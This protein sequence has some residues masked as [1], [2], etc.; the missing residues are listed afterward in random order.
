MK[1]I[2]YIAIFCLVGLWC[3]GT[4]VAENDPVQKSIQVRFSS[5]DKGEAL[6]NEI[7]DF[8]KHISP[9]LGRLGCNGRACHGSFQGQGGFMLSLFGYDF[10]VDHKALLEPGEDRVKVDVPDESLI[11]FKPTSDEQHEGG[12]RFDKDG[13]EYQVL[14]RWIE[15]GAQKVSKSETKAPNLKLEKLIVEP[16]ELVFGTKAQSANLN[17]VAVWNDGTR[18]DVTALSR[19]FSNDTS[20]AEIDE[21]GRVTSGQTG[22]THVVVS[23]D[24]AVVPIPVMRP[25]GPSGTLSPMIASSKSEVD[26]LVL[27]K[28]DKLGIQP[29][30]IASDEEF[31]R[32]VCLDVSGTLPT[33]KEVRDFLT[34]QTP[35]KRERAI[36]KLLASPGYAAIW[37]TFLCDITGNNEDQLRNATYLPISPSLYWYQWVYDRVER[38]VP[39]DQIVEGIV[40]A[41]SREPNET[42]MEFCENMTSIANDK[43]GKL[44]ASRSQM[45]YFWAR[46]N[47]QTAEERAIS[48][49][50]AFCGV[51]IQ[52][53][54]CHK[55]PFDQWSKK[56]FD[57]FESLFGNVVGRQGTLSPEGKKEID[58]IIEQLG[59]SKSVKGNQLARAI[60]DKYKNGEYDKT[61][62]FPEVI[63]QPKRVGDD[64]KNK[65][66]KS[67]DATPPKPVY[68]KL[69]G[70]D[71]ID[72][73][74]TPDPRTNLMQWLRDPGNP[75]FAKAFVNRVWAH[76]FQ[77]GIVNPADDLN[78]ANAPSNA[79]LLDYLARGFIEN[80]YDVKW[81]HRSILTSA[82]YQR[83]WRT[84]SSNE[85]DRRNFSHALLRR[86]P[87]ETA[88]DALRIAL[89]SDERASAIC[90]LEEDRAI[91]M[92][93]SS[94]QSRNRG[95][96]Y[97]LS[98]F[99][100]STRETNC[101][102][103]R[104]SDPSLLQTV[105]IRND[106]D[107]LQ[108]MVDP[109]K[110]WLAQ[111]AKENNWPIDMLRGSRNPN[112]IKA[113]PA[114][115]MM[116]QSSATD[117]ATEKLDR[118]VRSLRTQLERLAG[119]D[120]P[121]DRI[122][123][124]KT[125]L[126][127]AE[128]KLDEQNKRVE[129]LGD[130]TQESD[131]AKAGAANNLTANRKRSKGNEEKILRQ[132]VEEAFFRT[133]SRSP[134]NEEIQLSLKAIAEAPNPLSGLS[135]V[136]W[137]LINSKEFILNH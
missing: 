8:Q 88:Y 6:S 58:G 55:H 114:P 118:E 122:Q 89:S 36:E 39:Y 113:E 74:K 87:A 76:Y 81:V 9:L 126:A 64:G 45:P 124:I 20:I 70:G 25:F 54:Q 86:L 79:A 110:S 31:F 14:K 80:N 117:D 132:L 77:V 3:H 109:N 85:L 94:A 37:T 71:R 7:P 95:S 42:Y 98:V 29:A 111:V 104:T 99:G 68:A 49:A 65:N 106:N 92:P 11:L 84:N 40:T 59:V 19:F 52:C 91:T 18:E 127:R 28:L 101:D 102:C 27:S 130:A 136:L 22:D 66:K 93:G 50:Y 44:F 5:N 107:I 135:D 26:R 75:Y 1:S 134:S 129:K 33:S 73:S 48:F 67:K 96:N 61:I 60:R 2:K 123:N 62:P 35:D 125:R 119:K 83:S 90:N 100:R 43:T 53:A 105:F 38:N 4:V 15:H 137:A 82:T 97:A 32:R 21:F 121:P 17:A 30:D 115:G 63:N 112:N 51:R 103:D 10:D 24:A 41:V 120:T 128:K 116:G 16:A 72:L 78:L 13:W 133:L 131:T 46:N 57:Q 56:D 12:K 47:Q 23:Y 108:A 34:D 69:L